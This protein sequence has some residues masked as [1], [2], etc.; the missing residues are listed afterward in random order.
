MDGR[1]KLPF[2]KK[3]VT[4]QETGPDGADIG[5]LVVDIRG[6]SWLRVF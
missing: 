3:G 5:N 4:M 6:R 2:K 1:I